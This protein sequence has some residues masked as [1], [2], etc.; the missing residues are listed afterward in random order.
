MLEPLPVDIEPVSAGFVGGVGLHLLFQ[1]A[2]FFDGVRGVA[3]GIHR[4]DVGTG[5][6]GVGVLVHLLS[7]SGLLIGVSSVGRSA[8]FL[9]EDLAVLHVVFGD[10]VVLEGLALLQILIGARSWVE[11]LGQSIVVLSFNLRVEWN[12]F[13]LL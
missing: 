9:T 6:H 11:L 12:V 3:L 8:A 2:S 4:Q 5:R 1:G 13:A 7:H 10:E